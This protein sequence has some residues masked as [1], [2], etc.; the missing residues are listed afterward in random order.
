M[1]KRFMKK[2]LQSRRNSQQKSR[3]HSWIKNHW[4][5]VR[6]ALCFMAAVLLIAGIPAMDLNASQATSYTY[7]IDDKGYFVRT[8]DAYLPDKTI[9]DLGLASADDLF[10][11]DYNMLY[12]ADSGNKRIVKY[13]INKGIIAAILKYEDFNT[14]RGVFVTKAG[15]L[16]VADSAA[17]SVFRFNKDFELIEKFE[18]P[19]APAFA[20]TKFEPLRIAVDNIGNMYIVGEGVYNGIIQLAYTGEFIG[21]FTVNKTELTLAQA[22]QNFIFT[23]AQLAKL[24]ARTPATF[25]NIYIDRE[26]VVYTVSMGTNSTALKKHN[27]SGG[28]M[29]KDPIPSWDNVTD[30]Y[31]DK[32]GII[33]TSTARGYITAYSSTG[34]LIFEFGAFTQSLDVAGVFSS[35]PSLAIDNNRNIWTVD[36]DKG[37]IQS[38]KPTEYAMM[39]YSSMNLY[40]NGLYKESLKNWSDVL[41]LN[42]MSVLAHNGVGK[43]YLKEQNYEE[44]MLHFKLA[45]NREYYSEAFWEVRNE[46]IQSYLVLFALIIVALVLINFLIKKL[47]KKKKV[48]HFKKRISKKCMEVPVL[49]EILYASKV[50]KK[51]MDLYY[52]IR[53]NTKGNVLGATIIYALFFAVFMLYQTS[54]GFI[55]QYTAVEDLDINSIVIGFFAILGLFII[56]NYLVT[57]INDGDGSFKQVYMIPAYGCIPAMVMLLAITVTSYGMTYNESFILTILLIIGVAW[58]LI[59]IFLGLMTINDYTFRETVVSLFITVIFM[60]I[61]A[62]MALVIIIMWEKIWQFMLT[63]G[64][65]L[66]LNVFN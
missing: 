45:G 22:I 14:P 52:N 65:E 46:W 62:I 57:S 61:V 48:K 9:T 5:S 26:G 41:R 23:R 42:Q 7:T 17:K 1:N 31:V 37:Y 4:F 60:V 43:A 56:C 3:W 30:V 47:D 19:T 11:D 34:E 29:F 2:H 55:Y 16:Y 6:T 20:D 51:P 39:L 28:N 63:I 64:K 59:T 21:Y 12:I 66:F 32:E 18:K 54:K 36:G 13:D 25:S 38:F 8:Q 27:T 44:A 49:K 53:R 15:D 40:D 50:P 35:L 24:V 33:Y 58:S 10:I